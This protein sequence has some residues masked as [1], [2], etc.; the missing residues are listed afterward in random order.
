LKFRQ[1]YDLDLG[2]LY[3]I[4]SFSFVKK[5]EGVG[6]DW[7]KTKNVGREEQMS[8]PEQSKSIT[9]NYGFLFG[10]VFPPLIL[11][12]WNIFLKRRHEA[13]PQTY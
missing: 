1:N 7:M 2:Q 3:I 10:A 12:G 9:I 5:M 6:E 11:V 13:S 4:Y 8:N